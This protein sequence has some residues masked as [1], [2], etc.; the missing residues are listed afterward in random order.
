[1]SPATASSKQLRD[2]RM[3]DLVWMARPRGSSVE[4]P[5]AGRCEVERISLGLGCERWKTGWLSMEKWR[6]AS[7]SG[8][9]DVRRELT[10]CRSDVT[11]LARVALDRLALHLVLS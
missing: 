10:P 9:A 3:V 7:A 11:M 6:E 5:G 2:V 4:D 1:M 8:E